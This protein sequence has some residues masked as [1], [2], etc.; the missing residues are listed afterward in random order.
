MILSGCSEKVKVTGKPYSCLMGN[1]LCGDWLAAWTVGAEGRLV[2]M[3]KFFLGAMTIFKAKT[4][5]ASLT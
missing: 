1:Q 4:R 5:M 3:I 2:L